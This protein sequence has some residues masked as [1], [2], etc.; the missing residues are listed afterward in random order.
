[1]ISLSAEA[2]PTSAHSQ[3]SVACSDADFSVKEETKRSFVRNENQKPVSEKQLVFALRYKQNKNTTFSKLKRWDAF[4][5]GLDC[6]FITTVL[7]F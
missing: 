6:R 5:S 2:A 7:N 4:R 3:L 1:M